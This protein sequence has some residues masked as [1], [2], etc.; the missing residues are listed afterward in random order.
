MTISEQ[1]ERAKTDYDEVYHAGQLD[2]ISNAE[3]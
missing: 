3:A 1:I 2:I